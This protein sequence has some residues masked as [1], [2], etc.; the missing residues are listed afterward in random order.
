MELAITK[1]E[2]ATLV[3]SVLTLVDAVESEAK[4]PVSREPIRPEDHLGLVF[5][6]ASRFVPKH[7]PIQDSEE[8]SDGIMGLLR[9][10]KEYD[11]EKYQT[12]FS[13]YAFEVIKTAII[14]GWRKKNR[15]RLI[16]ANVSLS[17]PELQKLIPAK[18]NTSF[19]RLLEI[20]KTPRPGE[21]EQDKL[22]KEI[23]IEHFVDGKTWKQI[24]DER[25][26]T[27]AWAQQCG[28]KALKTIQENFTIEDF[29]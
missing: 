9:A 25:G 5:V 29:Q 12:Q 28:S 2:P 17:D 21:T 18:E 4:E 15:K 16:T 1:N 26:F 8:Y 3:K 11:P 24:G 19:P 14:Q 13:T 6:V 20:I 23:L 7:I 22:N 27:R 10:C